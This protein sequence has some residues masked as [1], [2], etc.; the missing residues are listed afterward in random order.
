[1]HVVS[2]NKNAISLYESL[3]FRKIAQLPQWFEFY[4]KYLNEL[5]LILEK[6]LILTSNMIKPIYLLIIGGP[7]LFPLHFFTI[8][9]I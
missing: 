7:N 4:G 3:G 2:S 5:V 8:F 6:K 1:M 9:K